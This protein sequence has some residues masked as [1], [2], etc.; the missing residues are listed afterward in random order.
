M[1]AEFMY[2][3]LAVLLIL[4]MSRDGHLRYDIS[5]DTLLGAAIFEHIDNMDYMSPSAHQKRAPTTSSQP[6]VGLGS[7]Y[8][9]RHKSFR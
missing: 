1:F 2:F 9:R 4:C 3:A 8:R 6:L 5:F 7:H